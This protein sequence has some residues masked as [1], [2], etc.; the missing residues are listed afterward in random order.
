IRDFHVTG[1][2]TC[3]LPIWESAPFF[4]RTD[5]ALVGGLRAFPPALVLLAPRL[6]R[7]ASLAAIVLAIAGPHRVRT[8]SETSTGGS[9]I[10]LA[11]DLSTSMLAEDLGEA[12]RLEIAKE[13][14]AR[15]ASRRTEDE[16]ALSAFAGEAFTRVPPT[17]DHDLVVDGV[18]SLEVDQIRNGTDLS[19]AILTSLK[20]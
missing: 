11:I 2:Q 15:F 4:N 9:A 19:G 5:R 13:A 3:A 14:A 18:R 1:V 7:S 12:S 20:R 10:V 17:R 16:L 8:V 6:L